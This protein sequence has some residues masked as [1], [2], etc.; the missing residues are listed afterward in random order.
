MSDSSSAP[1][2]PPIEAPPID[3]AALA[4]SVRRATGVPDAELITWTIEPLAYPDFG[5]GSR[6]LRRVSGTARVDRSEAPVAW[7]MVVK[8]FQ[9]TADELSSDDA[10]DYAYW[11]REASLYASG[12]L[13][14]L[15]PGIRAPR[16]YGVEPGPEREVVWLEDVH[17]LY[18]GGWS[19]ERFGLAA[20]HLGR[21]N[22]AFLG[23]HDVVDLPWVADL[24][25]VLEFWTVNEATQP[26]LAAMLDPEAWSKTVSAAGLRDVREPTVLR[27]LIVD[28]A[29]LVDAL[30]ELPATLCHHDATAPNLF[31]A[32]AVDGSDETVAI[33][34]QLAGPG[35][36]GAELSMLVA[37]SVLF[38][39]AAGA[40]IQELD[41]V[42]L[43]G[44]LAG[45]ADVGVASE[46]GVIKFAAAGA[47]VLRMSAIAAAWV[48]NLAT[49]DDRAWSAEFWNRPAEE[50]ADQWGPLLGHLEQQARIVEAWLDDPVRRTR[51]AS[52]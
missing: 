18:P 41:A 14:D 2:Q 33:D 7:S 46:P 32:H 23:R 34:W 38:H 19:F 44:Y 12:L 8:S 45:L 9:R 11:R 37:G 36:L 48:R 49:P 47:G 17:E 31:A 3:P 30:A 51:T 13:D 4:A 39:R 52:S 6:L 42:A 1:E 27:R 22:G 43:D 26:G 40:S 25:S 20:R 21:F 5:G 29:P 35:P 16:C 10:G 24:R 15:P 50:L 28:R